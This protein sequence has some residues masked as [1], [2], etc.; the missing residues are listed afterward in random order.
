MKGNKLIEFEEAKA[1][2]ESDPFDKRNIR[3]NFKGRDNEDIMQELDSDRS[4]LVLCLS[5]EIRDLNLSSCIRSANSFNI[6]HVVMAGRKNYDRRGT[7]GA[8]HYIDVKHDQDMMM[9]V[10]DYSLKGYRIVALEHDERFPMTEISQ[11]EWHPKTLLVAGEE[12]RSVPDYILA[13][14]LPNRIDGATMTDIVCIPMM[15]SVRSLN[16]ASAVSI[17]LYDYTTKN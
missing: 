5:N 8:H 3:D 4:E 9:T 13:G 1:L 11:Y 7:V 6:D 17:A 15:G 2:R 16:L 10:L 12:G 14:S